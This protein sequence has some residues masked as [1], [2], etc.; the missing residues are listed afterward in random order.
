MRKNVKSHSISIFL[1]N[2]VLDRN[3]VKFLGYEKD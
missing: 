3:V 1:T 2:F